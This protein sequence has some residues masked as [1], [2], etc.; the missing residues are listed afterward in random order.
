MRK[1]LVTPQSLPFESVAL[2]NTL[3]YVPAGRLSLEAPTWSY[4]TKA[5]EVIEIDDLREATAAAKQERI[6][7]SGRFPVSVATPLRSLTRLQL[8]SIQAAKIKKDAQ[9][10]AAITATAEP[11][12][13]A[14]SKAPTDF[15]AMS[16]LS[17]GVH[18]GCTSIQQ[19]TF[20]PHHFLPV[21]Y[22]GPIG[23]RNDGT[24]NHEVGA[25]TE[26]ID[27]SVTSRF[28]IARALDK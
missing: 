16:A 9:S 20:K 24:A 13:M 5:K 15:S 25:S 19:R 23:Y 1:S 28:Q 18:V 11:T 3:G 4:P 8:V 14:T 26:S 12:M 6:T 7:A 21:T 10:L 27:F 22:D 2:K 17:K